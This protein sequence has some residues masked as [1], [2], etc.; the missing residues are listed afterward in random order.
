LLPHFINFFFTVSQKGQKTYCFCASKYGKIILH[1]LRRERIILKILHYGR[2]ECDKNKRRT[3]LISDVDMIH[4]I[5]SGCGTFNH[6]KLS[7]GQ[8]FICRRD[9]LCD[10]MPDKDDPWTYSWINPFGS[11]VQQLLETLPIDRDGVF[12]WDIVHD[13]SSLQE[14][15]GSSFYRRSAAEEYRCLALLYRLAAGMLAKKGESS[16]SRCDYVEQA[17][18]FLQTHYARGVTIKETAAA[19]HLS[20]A[21]LRNLFYAQE[22]LSP[23]AYLMKLRMERAEFLLSGSYSI[24]EISCAVGYDDVLQFSRIFAKYHGVSPTQY[25]KELFEKEKRIIV[26]KEKI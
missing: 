21:Y 5:E 24:T 16:L 12:F 9:R 18:L 17:K 3:R 20:R 26:T 10:Y 13:L 11:D 15:C 1:K 7:A 2:E 25:R 14:V 4:F 23:Q 8:G 6:R 22:K 19:L